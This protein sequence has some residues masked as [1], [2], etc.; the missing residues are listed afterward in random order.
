MIQEI[1]IKIDDNKNVKLSERLVT[2]GPEID[3]GNN[4]TISSK[5][6]IFF[7]SMTC[8]RVELNI[9]ASKGKMKE[10][11]DAILEICHIENPEIEE[12][13][14]NTFEIDGEQYQKVER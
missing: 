14:E 10:I 9:T 8:N 7:I 2:A 4:D 5:R 12:I 6:S 3:V 11:S 13:D 1:E